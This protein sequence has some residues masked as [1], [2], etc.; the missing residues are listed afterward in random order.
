[1]KKYVIIGFVVV[2][3]VVV[4]IATH[5]PV[6]RTI[7]R[8]RQ[9]EAIASSAVGTAE[10]YMSLYNVVQTQLIVKTDSLRAL[11]KQ[12]KNWQSEKRAL[13]VD[14]NDLRQE[15]ASYVPDTIIVPLP[16]PVRPETLDSALIIIEHQNEYITYQ[17]EQLRSLTA[18]NITRGVI[19]EKQ[20]QVIERQE[21]YI[22]EFET[23]IRQYE[24]RSRRNIA[25]GTAAGIIIGILL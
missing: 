19:I 24:R 15:V 22:D 17:G 4:A 8:V 16:S 3:L 2:A 13:L 23:L 14:I 9:A 12:V 11:T 25:I 7:E 5:K 18:I 1:M 21:Q 10:R 6:V 20:D